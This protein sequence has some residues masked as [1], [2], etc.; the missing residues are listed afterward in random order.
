VFFAPQTL[1]SAIFAPFSFPPLCCTIALTE[2]ITMT[3]GEKIAALRKQR[4]ITQ[5]EIAEWGIDLTTLN[6]VIYSGHYQ[7][8]GK[9]LGTIGDFYK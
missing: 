1:H 7:S 3:T 4:G 5:E 2:A 9:Y 8:I 6:P